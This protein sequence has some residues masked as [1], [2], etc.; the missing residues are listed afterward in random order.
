M[1]DRP[2]EANTS[3]PT[4]PVKPDVPGQARRTRS[5]PTIPVMPDNPRQARPPTSSLTHQRQARPPPSSLT[6][7]TTL[8]HRLSRPRHQRAQV[9]KVPIALGNSRKHTRHP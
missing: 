9:L 8:A 3:C 7:P 5:S 4:I 1:P 6:H 2:C